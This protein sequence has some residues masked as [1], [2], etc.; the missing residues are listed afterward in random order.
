MIDLQTLYFFVEARPT[1][2]GPPNVGVGSIVLIVAT[3][4]FAMWIAWLW[5]AARPQSGGEEP[6]KNLQP[7]LSDGDLE[8]IRL[9]TVLRTAMVAA[10]VLALVVPIY[11]L[12][13]ADRQINAAEGI[14]EKDV[15]EGE[16]WFNQF[17]CINCHGADGGGGGASFVEVRSGLSTSWSAPSLND[18][19][20]RFDEEEISGII[21][22]G[23]QGTPMPA[24]GIPGGGAM[25]FQEVLQVMAYIED[26]GVTQGDVLRKIEPAV[27]SA[28]KRLETGDEKVAELILIQQAVIDDIADAPTRFKPIE[29]FPEQLSALL[30]GDGTC[31]SKSAALVDRVCGTSGIDTDR[32]GITDAAETTLNDMSDLAFEQMQTRLVKKVDGEF[33]VSFVETE[34]LLLALETDNPFSMADA[35]GML[36]SDLDKVD[37]FLTLVGARHLNLQVMT[38]RNDAFL[39]TANTSMDFL[40]QSAKDRMWFT[41][42][43]EVSANTGLSLDEATRAVGLY[44]AY[45]ARCHTGG[46]SA[47]V[48]YE[49]PA[50][51]GAWGPSL[52]DGR[53]DSQFARFE[54]HLKLIIKGTTSGQSYGINGIGTGRMPA[55]GKMLS[56]RDIELIAIYEDSM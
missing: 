53:A 41:D 29:T 9:N 12:N 25:T 2:T 52:L 33:V 31:T 32:D 13:E 14:H 19:F 50:G 43:S 44:N 28:I 17:S 45:C 56:Q 15:E 39:L 30:G 11:Y 27:D 51:S 47:G 54:D 5:I 23:R 26:F 36:E 10:A 49:Q 24:N 37:E 6:A 34:A 46:Y 48:A 20:F 18:L 3:A 8:N 21:N 40:V 4:M 35:S 22:H 42:F 7:Y 16:R 55:F 1:G 38:E